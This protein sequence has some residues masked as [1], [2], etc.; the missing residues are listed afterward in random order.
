[1]DIEEQKNHLIKL[2][3]LSK[4]RVDLFFDAMQAVSSDRNIGIF[5]YLR[6]LKYLNLDEFRELENEIELSIKS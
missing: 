2:I 5:T 4:N 6:A 1:M 3:N